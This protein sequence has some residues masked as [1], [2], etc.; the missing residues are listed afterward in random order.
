MQHAVQDFP[1]ALTVMTASS[2]T[3]S[4]R[5]RVT[6]GNV[7]VGDTCWVLTGVHADCWNG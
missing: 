6:A 7:M 3:V 1:N 4:L 5:A 2:N